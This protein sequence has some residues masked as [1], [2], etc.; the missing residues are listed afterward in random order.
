MASIG[1]HARTAF[2]EA[3]GGWGVIG[4]LEDMDD[5]EVIAPR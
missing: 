1:K 5:I 3:F 2:F 4:Q